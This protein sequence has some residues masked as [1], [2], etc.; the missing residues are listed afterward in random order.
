MVKDKK[1]KFPNFFEWTY[2][3]WYFWVIAILWSL[4]SGL[5]DIILGRVAEFI[6]TLIASI[7]LLSLLFLIA[8]LLS[9]N[10]CK[11]LGHI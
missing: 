9:R 4:W 7:A 1:N 5:E 3:K 11:K 8:W 10:T 6:G 2:T